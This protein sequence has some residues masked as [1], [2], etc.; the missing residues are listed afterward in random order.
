MTRTATALV[1]ALSFSLACDDDD[2][3]NVD[4]DCDVHVD[5]PSL[6]IDEQTCK[7]VGL[8]VGCLDMNGVDADALTDAQLEMEIDNCAA[9]FEFCYLNPALAGI[10]E[11][12]TLNELRGTSN[13]CVG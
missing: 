2:D 6:D 8:I 9:M 3:G 5:D 11:G 10:P 13:M 4:D 12:A 1:L 7:A